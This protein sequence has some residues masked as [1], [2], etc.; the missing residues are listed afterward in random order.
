MAVVKKTIW[1]N[2][3]KTKLTEEKGYC[4]FCLLLQVR[5]SYELQKVHDFRIEGM[6]SPDDLMLLKV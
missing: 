6:M 5:A 3:I 2:P 1:S 4:N